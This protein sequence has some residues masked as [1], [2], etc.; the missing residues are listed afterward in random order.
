MQE[1][2]QTFSLNQGASWAII[3][4]ATGFLLRLF[5][6]FVVEKERQ[7][8][9][10]RIVA[11]YIRVAI[12]RWSQDGIDPN[13][14]ETERKERPQFAK[15]V[16]TIMAGGQETNAEGYTPYVPFSRHDDL[17]VNDVREWLGFLDSKT[18]QHIVEFIQ[19]EALAHAL[20]DD[21]RSEYVRR[22][23]SPDRK[24]TLFRHFNNCVYEAFAW[25]MKAQTTLEPFEHCP[26]LFW[27]LPIG[28]ALRRIIGRL[29]IYLRRDS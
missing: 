1:T 18:L 21:F 4:G 14:T 16:E 2:Y 29:V 13:Q 25:G 10:L 27:Y 24:V 5:R 7:A 22:Q 12:K 11:V 8:T 6:D 20:A 3:A 26:K 15:V 19:N 23:L 28:N 9:G 17:S